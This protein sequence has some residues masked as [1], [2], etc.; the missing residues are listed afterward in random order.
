MGK[1]KHATRFDKQDLCLCL[2]F[3]NICSEIAMSLHFSPSPCTVP[4]LTTLQHTS[5]FPDEFDNR[6]G[7][8][9]LKSTVKL[10]SL[11]KLCLFWHRD[12]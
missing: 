8:S 1:R 2:V 3:Q 12:W 11:N 10:K 6:R 4:E 9:K 5:E 7:Q